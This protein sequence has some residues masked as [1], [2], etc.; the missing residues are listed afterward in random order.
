MVPGIQAF[1][2]SPQGL[3]HVRTSPFFCFCSLLTHSLTHPT[4]P[5]THTHSLTHS[6]THSTSLTQPPPTTL[7]FDNVGAPRQYF[8]TCFSQH[9]LSNVSR[10]TCV[11]T[12]SRC[13]CVVAWLM[14]L[15]GDLLV[16]PGVAKF[17]CLNLGANSSNLTTFFTLV[18]LLYD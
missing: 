7:P 5:P 4:R 13:S 2:C 18:H 12:L 10:Q 1:C 3:P 9:G 17:F 8:Y 16:F 14:L 15:H 11:K 6:L